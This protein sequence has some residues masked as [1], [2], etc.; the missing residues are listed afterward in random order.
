MEHEEWRWIEGFDGRYEVS[1]LGRVRSHFTCRNTLRAQPRV[2][3]AWKNNAGYPIVGLNSP[4]TRRRFLVHRLVATAF[5]PNPDCR[6][7]VNHKDSDPGNSSAGNLEWVT[8][9]Q[10][11]QHA[12]RFG[13]LRVP[14]HRG[15]RH[16]HSVLT[17]AQVLEIRRIYRC[18]SRETGQKSLARRYGVNQDTIANIVHGR[19]WTHI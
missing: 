6:P 4:T 1:S 12:Y 11:Q 19:T 5:V 14:R 17:E 7:H 16:P 9:S 10:N 18:G 2:L 13:R 3:R 8:R 15:E